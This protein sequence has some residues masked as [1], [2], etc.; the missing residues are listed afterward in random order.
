M[1]SAFIVGIVSEASRAGWCFSRLLA[2][3]EERIP[4]RTFGCFIIIQKQE[5]R[6]LGLKGRTFFLTTQT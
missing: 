5:I 6:W 1:T 4:R 3:G 2:P